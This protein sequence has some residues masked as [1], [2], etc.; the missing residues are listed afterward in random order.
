MSA[1]RTVYPEVPLTKRCSAVNPA[2]MVGCGSREMV[3]NVSLVVEFGEIGFFD[4]HSNI[5]AKTA[6]S[7]EPHGRRSALAK[8]VDDLLPS[9][10]GQDADPQDRSGRGLLRRAI[11]HSR[12]RQELS[13]A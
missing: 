9:S 7:G 2:R 10:G 4:L 8:L 5:F 12:I 13:P 3:E 1:I 6:I 11:R